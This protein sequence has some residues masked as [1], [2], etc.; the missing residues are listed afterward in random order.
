MNQFRPPVLLIIFALA[1][2]SSCTN[3]KPIAP[4]HQG[5]F[6]SHSNEYTELKE[7]TYWPTFENALSSG[8]IVIMIDEPNPKITVYIEEWAETDVSLITRDGNDIEL[9][10]T[11]SEPEAGFFEIQ[12]TTQLE[13]G[14]QY[15][16]VSINNNDRRHWCFAVTEFITP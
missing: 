13:A 2:F 8:R 11:Y 5:V 9:S 14:Q 7:F 16:L 1:V 10:V 15:C 12:P 3:S 6:L 4:E